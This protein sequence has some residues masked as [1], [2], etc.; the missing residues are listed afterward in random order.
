MGKKSECAMR[1]FCFM[2]PEAVSEMYE[3]IFLF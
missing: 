2:I 1:I 3:K